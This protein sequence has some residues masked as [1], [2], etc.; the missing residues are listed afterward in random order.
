MTKTNFPLWWSLTL[1]AVG[2]GQDLWMDI[3]TEV[4]NLNTHGVARICTC[5]QLVVIQTFLMCVYIRSCCRPAVLRA[6]QDPV[7]PRQVSRCPAVH[8]VGGRHHRRADCGVWR[9]WPHGASPLSYTYTRTTPSPP[10]Y[11]VPFIILPFHLLYINSHLTTSW[12]TSKSLNLPF[13][14]LLLCST[15][16][17]S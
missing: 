8:H 4:D 5:T 9:P 2:A 13:I 16:E 15:S 3:C 6:G 11:G 14:N 1:I 17:S 10:C 7:V 12:D